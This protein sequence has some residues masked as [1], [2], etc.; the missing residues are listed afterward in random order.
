MAKIAFNFL[1][2]Q[3]GFSTALRPDF[4]DI[5]EFILLGRVPNLQPVR[6]TQDP[7]VVGETKRLAITDGHLVTV[8]FKG[9]NLLGMVSP[10]NLNKYH[11]VLA[12][13]YTGLHFPDF[14]RCF[15]W[16]RG[17]ILTMIKGT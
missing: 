2:H 12:Q 5:R 4:N 7:V 6:V 10:Y 15:D 9:P 14:G 8:S 3:R 11:V 17:R 13:G 16:R 1:A